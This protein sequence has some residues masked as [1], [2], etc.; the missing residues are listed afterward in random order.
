MGWNKV[1]R[2]TLPTQNESNNDDDDDDNAFILLKISLSNQTIHEQVLI[3]TLLYY[4]CKVYSILFN[5][6][7]NCQTNDDDDVLLCR[8]ILLQKY[9]F[10]QTL[11]MYQNSFRNTVSSPT[12]FSVTNT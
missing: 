8:T 9:N 11:E 1:R 10:K 12:E 6:F 3:Y 7:Q 2:N 5:M 4:I